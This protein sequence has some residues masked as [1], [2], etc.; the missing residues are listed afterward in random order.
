MGIQVHAIHMPDGS[1]GVMGLEAT[2]GRYVTATCY[3]MDEWTAAL[4]IVAA[5]DDIEALQ[6]TATAI[7]AGQWDCAAEVIEL[8][9]CLH[10]PTSIIERVWQARCA[11][12]PLTLSAGDVGT[13]YNVLLFIKE[14]HEAT[15]YPD[16]P[17]DVDS[18]CRIQPKPTIGVEDL[19]IALRR[20]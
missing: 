8:A 3:T 7:W 13:L 1:A 10:G 12:K 4:A 18:G 11:N 16:D 20:A 2:T 9:A 17:D 15:F 19:L 6:A 5:E 14:T